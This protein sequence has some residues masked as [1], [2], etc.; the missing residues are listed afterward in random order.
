MIHVQTYSQAT[1]A[2]LNRVRQGF[3]R[4]AHMRPL[5][6]V[7]YGAL[8]RLVQ[9]TPKKWTGQTRRAWKVRQIVNRGYLV[10]NEYKVMWFLEHGTRAHGPRVKKALYIPL[11]RRAAL[12]GW[13]PELVQGFDYLLRGWVRGI[14]PRRIAARERV[15]V[16]RILRTEMARFLRGFL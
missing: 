13:T 6:R 9:A 10:M 5:R 15:L 2:Y 14:A 8:R 4:G 1:I 11:N 3:R 16:R 7:A 12:G